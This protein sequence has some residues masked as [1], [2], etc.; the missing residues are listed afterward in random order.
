MGAFAYIIVRYIGS[1][2]HYLVHVFY[3]GV[4]STV[5]SAFS[6]FIFHIQ[7]PIMPESLFDWIIHI[8]IAISAFIGQCLLNIGLKFCGTKP[9]TFVNIYI[10]I[11]IYI[12][13]FFFIYTIYLN[14]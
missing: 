8:L 13:F 3:F 4:V 11:Y 1:G 14:K 7:D 12:F 10:Y 9:R 5:I 6:L 2:V